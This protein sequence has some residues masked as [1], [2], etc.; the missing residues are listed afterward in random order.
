[1]LEQLIHS[2]MVM[3]SHVSNR[4]KALWLGKTTG[5]PFVTHLTIVCLVPP[6]V[7]SIQTVVEAAI[8][9]QVTA[10]LMGS[11]ILSGRVD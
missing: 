4:A 6:V 7:Y 8:D 3:V 5:F 10:C 1:M 11:L 2:N 9:V